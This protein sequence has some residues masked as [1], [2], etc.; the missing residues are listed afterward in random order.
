MGRSWKIFLKIKGRGVGGGCVSEFYGLKG[1]F[2]G[3]RFGTVKN[4][5][6]V[7]VISRRHWGLKK[8]VSRTVGSNLL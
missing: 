6:K 4:K 7:T 2:K 3:R 5:K 1:V 8:E